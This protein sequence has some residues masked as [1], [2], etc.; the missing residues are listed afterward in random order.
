M[1]TVLVS[2][3]T[4]AMSMKAHCLIQVD[5]WRVKMACLVL[6]LKR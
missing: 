1:S 6:E 2:L 5:P 4:K 3:A